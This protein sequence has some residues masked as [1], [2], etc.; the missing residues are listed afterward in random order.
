MNDGVAARADISTA[1]VHDGAAAGADK[2]TTATHECRV[3]GLKGLRQQHG[4]DADGYCEFPFHLVLPSLPAM[5]YASLFL[6]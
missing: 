6:V 5:H 2:R 1:A 3:R 4:G